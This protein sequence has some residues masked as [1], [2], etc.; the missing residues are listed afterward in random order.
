MAA[1]GVPSADTVATVPPMTSLM[2]RWTASAERRLREKIERVKGLAAVSD[3]LSASS[4][5]SSDTVQGTAGALRAGLPPA[6]MASTPRHVRGA[7]PIHTGDADQSEIPG[8]YLRR[9]PGFVP[10][11]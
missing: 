7:S 8:G 4:R 9:R 6:G 1:C 3:A 10:R 11:G 5:A 2:M